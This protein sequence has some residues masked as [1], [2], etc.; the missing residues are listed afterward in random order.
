MIRLN[1]L[2]GRKSID[3]STIDACLLRV[4]P[5]D[6]PRKMYSNRMRFRIS[7]E[8]VMKSSAPPWTVAGVLCKQEG[9]YRIK[10][11]NVDEC[12]TTVLSSIE[13]KGWNLYCVD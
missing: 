6:L 11:L 4:P 8:N 3:T 13:Y 2:M 7:P 5:P 12:S 10:L 9:G 1:D